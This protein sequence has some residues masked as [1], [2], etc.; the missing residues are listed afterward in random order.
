MYSQ[1][2]GGAT[3]DSTSREQRCRVY[4][5]Q[6]SRGLPFLRQASFHHIGVIANNNNN[7]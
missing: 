7:I 4:T 2:G 3:Q 5:F 1:H 6:I